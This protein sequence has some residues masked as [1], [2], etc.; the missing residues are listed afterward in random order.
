VGIPEGRFRVIHTG[1]DV[2]Q[3]RPLSDVERREVRA[4]L[5]IRED[6]RVVVSAGSLIERKGMDRVL[7]AWEQVRPRA[8]RDLLL[9]A[10]PASLAEGLRREDLPHA[11]AIRSAAAAPGLDGTVRIVG[12][13]KDLERYLGMADLFVFLSRREGLG[14]VIIEAMACGVPSVVSP[15]DG[16]GRELI[17]EGETG[18][19]M[20]DP[21]A[22]PE[23]GERISQ[24]L[25]E[26]GARR[27]LGAAARRAASER[28]SMARRAETLARLYR[29][30]A[31]R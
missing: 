18:F 22:A 20:E 10:G 9:I 8:G 16:I 31:E 4:S 30:L 17:A 5:G 7:R 3:Y 12:R 27:G 19:V 2:E 21:D 15:L 11:E 6:A 28:F 24:L 14:N 26:P 29:E 23:V 25:A 13:V 1:V